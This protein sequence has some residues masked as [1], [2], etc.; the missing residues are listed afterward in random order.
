MIGEEEE[1]EEEYS[2]DEED[3]SARQKKPR[4]LVRIIPLANVYTFI[5]GGVSYI[6]NSKVY[7]EDTV[8][9]F[10]LKL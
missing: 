2:T 4:G 8:L 7:P 6:T 10:E 3:E 9:Q 1:E 5:F